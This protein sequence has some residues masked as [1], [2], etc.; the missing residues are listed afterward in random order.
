[1]SIYDPPPERPSTLDCCGSGCVPCILDVY[2]EEYSRWNRRQNCEGDQL[3]RDLLSITKFKDYKIISFQE[4]GNDVYM[5]TFAA[6]PLSKGRLPITDTQHVFVKSDGVIR[7]YTP[8]ALSDNCSFDVI[9]KAYPNGKF[10]KLLLK[11][12]IN[13]IIFVRGP[14]GGIDYKG[15]ESIVMF[16]AGTGIAAYLGLIRSI[17]NN[18][19]CD[20]LLKLHYSCKTLNGILMRK[21]LAEYSAYWNCTVFLYL[22]RENNWSLCSKSFWYNEN[23]SE[24]RISHDIIE[25]IINQQQSLQTLWLICGNDEFNQFIFN[26]LKIVNIKKDNIKIFHNNNKDLS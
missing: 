22:T 2:E 20:I 4:L 21:T 10:T 1:M 25:E 14:S 16:C 11:K 24:G 18:D 15:Y 8:V 17:L 7:P 19:K 12:K 23:I 3:R 26:E 5:Y 9:I 13:D 6:I